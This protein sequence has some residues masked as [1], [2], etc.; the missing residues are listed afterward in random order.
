MVLLLKKGIDKKNILK[1]LAKLSK[2]NEKSG[3]DATQ[4]HGKLKRGIDGLQFQKK[5][6]D[7]WN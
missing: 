3:F 4:F 7:E 2:G 5:L 6:R 1:S